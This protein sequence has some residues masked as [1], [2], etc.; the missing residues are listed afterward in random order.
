MADRGFDTSRRELTDHLIESIQLQIGEGVVELISHRAMCEHAFEFKFGM[1]ADLL[2]HRDGFRRS[3][4]DAIHPGIDLE[5][6]QNTAVLVSCG[7]SEKF[8]R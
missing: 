1:T 6:H 4:T 7:S 2:G 3:D 8:D 5:M